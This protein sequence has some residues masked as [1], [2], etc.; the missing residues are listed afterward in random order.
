MSEVELAEEEQAQ[1]VRSFHRLVS[2][3]HANEYPYTLFA[4]AEL[5]GI[6]ENDLPHKLRIDTLR[7]VFEAF[8]ERFKTLKRPI[9]L[10]HTLTDEQASSRKPDGVYFDYQN[11][12]WYGT[13][14]H[15]YAD[16]KD[17]TWGERVVYFVNIM[18]P[19]DS[20]LYTKGYQIA[21]RTESTRF[22]SVGWNQ[23]VSAVVTFLS[24]YARGFGEVTT[25]PVTTFDVKNE[26][27]KIMLFNHDGTKCFSVRWHYG[28][29]DRFHLNTPSDEKKRIFADMLK[30]FGK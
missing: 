28:V 10:T 26:Q 8:A 12:S 21:A 24:P 5:L 6:A 20:Y 29:C 22:D 25:P 23:L 7:E 4:K 15:C 13:V 9:P 2:V 17:T 1:F 18:V 11:A 27:T 16:W 3:G 19:N 30:D 14:D